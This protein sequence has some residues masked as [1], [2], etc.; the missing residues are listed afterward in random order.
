[1]WFKKGPQSGMMITQQARQRGSPI[2]ADNPEQKEH[3]VPYSC[4]RLEEIN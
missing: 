4:D 1:M 3:C 2:E